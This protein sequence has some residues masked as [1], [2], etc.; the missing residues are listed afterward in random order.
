M[1]TCTFYPVDRE[2]KSCVCSTS[3]SHDLVTKKAQ[4]SWQNN[5]F[6]NFGSNICTVC[7]NSFQVLLNGAELQTCF[8]LTG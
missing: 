5:I 3:S 2:I 7:S 6:I 8:F 1:L 4:L